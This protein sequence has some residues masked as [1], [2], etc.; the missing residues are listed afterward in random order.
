MYDASWENRDLQKTFCDLLFRKAEQGDEHGFKELT[1]WFLSGPHP[2]H[3]LRNVESRLSTT[4][5][6]V[7]SD[8]G[9]LNIAEY[10]CRLSR[11]ITHVNEGCYPIGQLISSYAPL[12]FD[13]DWLTPI[14]DLV[15]FDCTGLDDYRGR[16]KFAKALWREGKFRDARTLLQ[17]SIS[18][19]Q[20]FATWFLLQNLAEDVIPA[21][22]MSSVDQD[23]VR[24]I[25]RIGPCFESYSADMDKSAS[26]V[27]MS[28]LPQHDRSKLIWQLSRRGASVDNAAN[29]G[30]EQSLLMN[31]ED[32]A[33][34]C[35]SYFD[36]FY[37]DIL[38]GPRDDF[39]LS[40]LFSPALTK[41]LLHKGFRGN[42]N[43]TIGLANA[44]GMRESACVIK[45]Y[46]EEV[47]E[48]RLEKATEDWDKSSWWERN[49]GSCSS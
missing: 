43:A 39:L 5:M 7:A 45:Q 35:L 6:G 46:L 28:C 36:S 9:H 49:R 29:A 41:A 30:L 32:Q 47:E 15:L 27:M 16:H 48:A 33:L 13:R 4:L 1:Q 23:F 20:G 34:Y 2:F 22:L 17:R 14:T 11:G 40:A 10:I 8:N 19:R 24:L 25:E 38:R 31:D 44:K 42:C 21:E 18:E 26:V 37:S 12:N 3:M